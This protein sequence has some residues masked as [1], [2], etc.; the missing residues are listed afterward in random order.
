MWEAIMKAIDDQFVIVLIFILSCCNCK[1][2]HDNVE[3]YCARDWKIHHNLKAYI[4]MIERKWVWETHSYS[5][6]SKFIEIF[7]FYFAPDICFCSLNI[8]V[9]LKLVGVETQW[10]TEAEC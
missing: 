3:L 7:L 4:E 9:T 2:V 1:A 8:I 6:F 5:M 10:L